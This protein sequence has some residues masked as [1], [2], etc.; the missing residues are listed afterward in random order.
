[1]NSKALPSASEVPERRISLFGCRCKLKVFVA[2][3][4]SVFSFFLMFFLGEGF[5]DYA[6]FIGMG[7][8]FLICQYLLSHG[9]L[10][11]YTT[12]LSCGLAQ[13]AARR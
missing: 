1:M 12:S 4:L 8:Y 7:A 11:L 9:N 3:I 5:G 6:T 2:V 10:H 13:N